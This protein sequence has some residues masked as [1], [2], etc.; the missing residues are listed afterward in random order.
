MCPVALAV[1]LL[2]DEKGDRAVRSLWDRLEENG[3]PS[4]RSHTHG[5]HSP[6][7][8]Y[9]VLRS[10]SRQAVQSAI[11]ALPDG[12]P[13]ALNFDGIGTFRRGRTWLI[14]GV[15]AALLQRQERVVAAATG[16]GADLHRNYVPGI[17][18]PHCS[19]APRVPLEQL[20]LLV[21]VV[22]QFLPLAVVAAAAAL[23][24]SGTGQRWLLPHVP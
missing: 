18:V 17:W 23:I 3:V 7:L 12:G 15:P 21:S 10:W 2:L 8:S 22:N 24:D 20:P 19:V 14:P 1:C 13:V 6:H 5:G 16:T 11:E 4:M 9:A